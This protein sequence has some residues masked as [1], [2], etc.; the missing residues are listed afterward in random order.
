MMKSF[1]T[2]VIPLEKPGFFVLI[3]WRKFRSSIGATLAR[4]VSEPFQKDQDRGNALNR[5]KHRPVDL[6]GFRKFAPDD[7]VRLLRIGCLRNRAAP[8]LEFPDNVAGQ[9]REGGWR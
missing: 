1:L 5:T 4:F 7:V 2:G 8:A 9:I 3:V 6:A